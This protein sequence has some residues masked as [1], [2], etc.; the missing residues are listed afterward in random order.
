[1]CLACWE[2][3]LCLSLKNILHRDPLHPVLTSLLLGSGLPD[4]SVAGG[5]D[6]G[7]RAARVR[8]HGTCQC[9]FVLG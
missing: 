9:P 7:T 4:A 5:G 8:M 6:Q 1:M 3:G 2:S